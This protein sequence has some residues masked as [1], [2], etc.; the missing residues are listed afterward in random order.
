MCPVRAI[1][2]LLAIWR[3]LWI[4]LILI[5]FICMPLICIFILWLLLN[6]TNIFRLEL[7]KLMRLPVIWMHVL[8]FLLG[9]T[10]HYKSRI[11]TFPVSSHVQSEY[12][13]IPNKPL[14]FFIK[15]E[16]SQICVLIHLRVLIRQP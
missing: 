9:C 13:C 12:F 7:F 15:L 3:M 5:M 16:A 2:L 1:E 6:K 10:I 4:M 14:V 11:I 8:F